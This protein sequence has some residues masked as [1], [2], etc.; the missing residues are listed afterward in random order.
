MPEY[1][2]AVWFITYAAG[3]H[4]ITPEILGEHEIHCIESYTITWRESK[5]TLLRLG[6]NG[7]I[8]GAT[9]KRV[10]SVLKADHGIKGS[11]IH[12]YDMLSSN[13]KADQLITDHPGFMRM[14]QLLNE[15]IDE[16]RVWM[17][18]GDLFT[19]KRG[20]LW[21]YIERR[22]PKRMS[23]SQLLVKLS[24]LEQIAKEHAQLQ[25]AHEAL[26]AAFAAQETEMAKLRR[27]LGKQRAQ[28]DD[29]FRQLCQQ[30]EE[31]GRL[32][33]QLVALGHPASE[34]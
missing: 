26:L 29:F 7:K 33:R 3:S 20:L 22:D 13:S 11:M 1:P 14:V 15:N 2:K 12:G 21:K 27:D 24:K 18:S 32:K 10:M 9:L 28:N 5:Y 25:P 30:I 8:R 17:K 4:D 16:L 34:S 6:Q 23:R 31:C 19:N